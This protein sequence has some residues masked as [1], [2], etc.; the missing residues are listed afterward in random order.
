MA[1]ANVGI[2]VSAID[3]ASPVLS[4]IMAKINKMT[5]T[6]IKIGAAM[7]AGGALLRN[8]AQNNMARVEKYIGSYSQ[9]EDARVQLENTLMK[10][11]GSVSEWFAA[12]NKEAA[13][14]GNKLPGTTADFYEMASALS[15]LNVAEKSI[16][17][18]GLK[19]TAYLGVGTRT[20][21]D[22]SAE[23]V[24]KF[25]QALGIA[26]DQLLPFI[27]DV[28]RMY[29]MGIKV[30][31]M[32]Y[33]F[34]R[35]GG[36]LKSMG[37]A[38]LQGARDIEPLIGVLIQAGYNGETVGT[39][40][41]AILNQALGFSNSKKSKEISKKYGIKFNFVDEAGNFKGVQNLVAE[42]E[43]LQ[44]IKSDLARDDV[45]KSIFGSGEDAQMAKILASGGTKAIDEFTQKM[46]A[47][48]DL[49]KRVQN[50]MKTISALWEA[51]TGTLENVFASVTEQR[52]DEIHAA[53][54]W[55][56]E[57][58]GAAQEFTKKHP[59]ITKFFG[60]I[61]IGLPLIAGAISAVLIPL[62]LMTTGFGVLKK[63]TGFGALKSALSSVGG[64]A[65][66]TAGC[67][68]GAASKLRGLGGIGATEAIGILALAGAFM[69]LNAE[70][71]K[72]GK[73]TIDLSRT[74]GKDKETLEAEIVVAKERL[75]MQEKDWR[76]DPLGVALDRF[77][78]GEQSEAMQKKYKALIKA[79]ERAIEKI[80]NNQN[81]TVTVHINN[82]VVQTPQQI[83][84]IRADAL[85]GVE[86]A[87]K[88]AK[89]VDANAAQRK[90]KD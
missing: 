32:Q 50:S 44:T 38:G 7:T 56:G 73:Q 75:K 54:E 6:E 87:L 81:N 63:I 80:E 16:A 17:N 77:L 11:D 19:A 20:P 41:T 1:N 28:Q 35:V 52:K 61:A 79:K 55:F 30:Q 48:A 40:L 84:Q 45:I 51:F 67:V 64:T 14:L 39:G 21:Y 68:D 42:L 33:A 62:G 58:A 4:G 5:N 24:A 34:S 90:L 10:S 37:Q 66:G 9:L 59:T 65:C 89:T 29:H 86:V 69:W 27:D 72:A 70:I 49:E 8:Y 23:A 60:A 12:I 13:T 15:A 47:Q 22:Q 25:K 53:I 46:R 85:K 36:S 2:I 71:A 26:D 74:V 76:Q 78:H 3:R 18:G 57:L 31:E 88:N 43:K 82:P 83:A